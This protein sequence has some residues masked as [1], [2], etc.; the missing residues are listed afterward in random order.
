M[1]ITLFFDNP[2]W[3]KKLKRSYRAGRYVPSSV[4]ELHAL[5]PFASNR[6]EVEKLLAKKGTGKKRGPKPKEKNPG[7]GL[8]LLG[9]EGSDEESGEGDDQTNGSKPE[10]EDIESDEDSDHELDEESGEGTE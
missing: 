9:D 4:E 5:L 3:C 1:K 10:D 2:G 8:G 6:E 7:N